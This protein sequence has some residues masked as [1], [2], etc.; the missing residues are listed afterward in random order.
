VAAYTSSQQRWAVP[1]GATE[2]V[3]V[4]HGASEG[5]DSA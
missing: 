1:D 2:F 5:F 4:R 3:L